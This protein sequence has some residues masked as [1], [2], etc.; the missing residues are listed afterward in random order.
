MGQ[1][2]ESFYT[3]VKKILTQLGSW[4]KCLS[5]LA[6]SFD[7]AEI[8]TRSFDTAKLDSA[9]SWTPLSQTPG[10]CQWHCWFKLWGV[11]DSHRNNSIKLSICGIIAT[12]ELQ[13]LSQKSYLRP[14]TLF[15]GVSD[16]LRS[17]EWME[18]V[19]LYIVQ[20]YAIQSIPRI[21]KLSNL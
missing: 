18:F 1:C 8:L 9:V 16:C 13:K 20:G 19:M 6:Y 17:E 3:P 21:W 12:L 10:G 7:F 4:F 2:H 5:I 11:I 14:N 15:C